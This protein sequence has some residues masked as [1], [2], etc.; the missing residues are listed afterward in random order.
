MENDDLG[1]RGGTALILL[2]AYGIWMSLRVS[3]NILKKQ[4][5]TFKEDIIIIQIPI[6]FGMSS[7]LIIFLG[8]SYSALELIA[9]FYKILIVGA[10]FLY[11]FKT[12][13][14]EKP[15]VYGRF[16]YQMILL[17]KLKIFFF[18]YKLDECKSV[19][20]YVKI[21]I[22]IYVVYSLV[23]LTKV[24]IG[25]SLFLQN[26]NF[27]SWNLDKWALIRSIDI[28]ITLLLFLNLWQLK[29]SIKLI[30]INIDYKYYLVA[31]PVIL[32]TV[33]SL[34]AY[35][36]SFNISSNSNSAIIYISN[37][38]VLIEMIILSFYQSSL[39]SY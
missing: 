18:N 39:Y 11:L 27:G 4:T 32:H 23:L 21:Q 16:Q 19:N 28:G 8:V 17:S 10:F 13:C 30:G 7:W 15:Y 24:G 29:E 37:L 38:F 33:H 1:T 22:I 26:E 9:T 25:V 36:I 34:I 14:S 12:I 3:F 35:G 5:T 2:L 20:Q 6:I 31:L